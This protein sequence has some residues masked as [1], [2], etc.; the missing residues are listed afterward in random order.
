MGVPIA[1][2]ESF[3]NST[4]YGLGLYGTSSVSPS[5]AV[6][7][8]IHFSSNPDSS[9][10]AYVFSAS[11]LGQPIGI[12]SFPGTV[13]DVTNSESPRRL[14]IC[15][16]ENFDS[17][18]LWNPTSANGMDLEYLTI[19]SSDYDSTGLYYSDSDILNSDV[20]YFLG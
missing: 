6:D 20:Q 3:D 5:E 18:M 8:D 9:S 15:F 4:M 16:F 13:W 19:M 17:D 12:G 14:N 7:V 2:G 10:V 1:G 11:N